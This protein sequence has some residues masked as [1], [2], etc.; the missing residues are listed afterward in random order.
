MH[1]MSKNI[2]GGST[3]S[4]SMYPDHLKEGLEENAG[5]SKLSGN[6]SILA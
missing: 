2:Q 1:I 6:E 5:H 4:L 3:V